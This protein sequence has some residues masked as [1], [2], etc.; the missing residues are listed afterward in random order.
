MAIDLAP[1]HRTIPADQHSPTDDYVPDW[2]ERIITV[3]A[4]AMAVVLVA[5]VAVLM[6]SV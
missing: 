6:G 2:G 3:V 5:V 1:S 4:T